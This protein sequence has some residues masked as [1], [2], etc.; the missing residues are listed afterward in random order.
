MSDI[1]GLLFSTPYKEGKRGLD[2]DE[3]SKNFNDI[4]DQKG[5]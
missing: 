3:L 4:Y 5:F 2:M 1:N